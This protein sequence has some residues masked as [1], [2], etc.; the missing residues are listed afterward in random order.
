MWNIRLWMNTRTW[1][2]LYTNRKCRVR[3]VLPS[4]Q[5]SELHCSIMLLKQERLQNMIKFKRIFWDVRGSFVWFYT[6]AKRK[7][8]VSELLQKLNRFRLPFD[9]ALRTNILLVCYM[10]VEVMY[11]YS[12]LIYKIPWW[13]AQTG[14]FGRGLSIFT[15][16]GDQQWEECS[17]T[18]GPLGGALSVW[19]TPVWDSNRME[20]ARSTLS[21]LSSLGGR[22]LLNLN[23]LFACWI[24]FRISSS[25]PPQ[26]EASGWWRRSEWP[27][28]LRTGGTDDFIPSEER[29][30]RLEIE[31]IERQHFCDAVESNVELHLFCICCKVHIW[32]LDQELSYKQLLCLIVGDRSRQKHWHTVTAETSWQSYAQHTV[33]TRAA[34]TLVSANTRNF[35]VVATGIKS[36]H[37]VALG[38][39]NVY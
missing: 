33:T 11:T 30:T 24:V 19:S 13:P 25:P 39:V 26:T 31:E 38:N 1:Q 35:V 9:P 36:W 16:S 4:G 12:L 20:G 8:S 14:T 37:I 3:S 15:Y 22:A 18:S 28:S 7:G 23:S 21:H 29:N 6:V 17:A 27:T 5:I 10:C 2:M 32:P 34:H